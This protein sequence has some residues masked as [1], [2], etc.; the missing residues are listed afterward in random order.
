MEK[1]R[2]S[3]PFMS[4]VRSSGHGK[5]WTHHTDAEK[6]K[7]FGWKATTQESNYEND[8]LIG[9]WNEERFDIDKLRHESPLPSQVIYKQ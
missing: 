9:N 1:G 3:P 5:S 6:F 8:T 4:M 2:S 7:E